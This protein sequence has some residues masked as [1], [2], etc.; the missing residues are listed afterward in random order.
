MLKLAHRHCQLG[1]LRVWA[2]LMDGMPKRMI[3][4]ALGGSVYLNKGVLPMD[5]G[6]TEE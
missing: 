3:A 5:A 2:S 6:G 4:P 1:T